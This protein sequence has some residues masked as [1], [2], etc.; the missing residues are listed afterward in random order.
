MGFLV[1]LNRRFKE[2]VT[3]KLDFESKEAL[4]TQRDP[5]TISKAEARRIRKSIFD[6]VQGINHLNS[7]ICRYSYYHA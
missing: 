3:D 2:I 5:S 7:F 1:E 6:L 4:I